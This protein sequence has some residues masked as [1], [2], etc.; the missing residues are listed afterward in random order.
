M[1]RIALQ[2][3]LGN[4]MF[5]YAAAHALAKR[6]GTHVEVGRE[7]YLSHASRRQFE[8]WRFAA[9]E[10]S[11]ITEREIWLAKIGGGLGLQPPVASYSRDGLGFDAAVLELPDGSRLWAE[12]QS[13]RYFAG[14]ERD[15]RWL[16]DL[17]PFVAPEAARALRAGGDAPIV[18][19]HLRRGDYVGNPMFFVD[20]STYVQRAVGYFRSRMACRF[21]VFSDDPAWCKAQTVFQAPDMAHAADLGLAPGPAINDMALMSVCDHQ[22]ISNSSFSW[23]AAW[24]NRS[25]AK[26]VVMPSQWL[27]DHSTDACGLAVDGWLQLDVG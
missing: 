20:L 26:Q 7:A 18:G 14:A 3:R 2:G 13:P 19:I 8:L 5:Q 25:P 12:L 21:M 10:L 17:A 15:V 4:Q 24:L 27:A 1:I 22:I 9:L 16:L 6:R 23:W 11:P